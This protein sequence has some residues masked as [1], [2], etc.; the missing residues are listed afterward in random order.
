MTQL[1]IVRIAV[2]LLLWAEWMGP[3]RPTHH[4]LHPELLVLT[5]LPWV[6]SPFLLF[7][8]FSRTAAALT[9]ASVLGIAIYGGGVALGS[10]EAWLIGVMAL[11]L[12]FSPCG[13]AFSVD[14]IRGDAGRTEQGGR[15]VFRALTSALFLGLA[16]DTLLGPAPMGVRIE[17]LLWARFG[18]TT[19]PGVAAGAAWLVVGAQLL[20]AIA[21]WSKRLRRPVLACIGLLLLLSYP[22][23]YLGSFSVLLAILAFGSMNS[24]EVDGALT[25]LGIGAPLQAA[26]PSAN[27]GPKQ[28]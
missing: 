20:G 13:A 12:A 18:A 3:L 27:L 17:Q 4:W 8:W 2:V 14:A 23:F 21:P 15:W 28:T 11:A 24:A 5:L 10:V 25:A 1:A 19:L 16:L 7:G 22:V 26:A 6:F 9:G